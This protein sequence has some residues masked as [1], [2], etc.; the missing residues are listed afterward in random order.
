MPLGRVLEAIGLDS[1][2]SDAEIAAHIRVL[3]GLPPES[4][5]PILWV[6]I[7]DAFTHEVLAVIAPSSPH[8]ITEVPHP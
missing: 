4:D 5:N 3:S 7:L 6:G 2:A 1:S 8:L